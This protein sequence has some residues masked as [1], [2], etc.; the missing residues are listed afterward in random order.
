VVGSVCGLHAS[1]H[2]YRR[3]LRHSHGIL[4]AVQAVLHTGAPIPQHRQ[5]VAAS[6]AARQPDVGSFNLRGVQQSY[7]DRIASCKL[8]ERW[9][10]EF[11]KAT[12][13]TERLGMG[14]R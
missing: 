7:A 4:R 12:L 9:F 10:G 2:T 11:A 8:E 1:I 5:P 3:G 14:S 13:G 6:A